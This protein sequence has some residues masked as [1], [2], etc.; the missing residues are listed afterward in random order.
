MSH[1]TRPIASKQ[2]LTNNKFDTL[3]HEWSAGKK[4][5]TWSDLLAAWVEAPPAP[6]TPDLIVK[7]IECV[8][9]Q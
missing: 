5:V 4:E 9:A 8:D 1:N 3:L 6:P 2:P 7:V